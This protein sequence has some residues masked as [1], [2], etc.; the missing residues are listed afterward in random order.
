MKGTVEIAA[1]LARV[2]TALAA[3]ALAGCLEW[4]PTEVESTAAPEPPDLQSLT[5]SGMPP[6]GAFDPGDAAGRCGIVCRRYTECY[7]PSANP[8][9]CLSRCS[10]EQWVEDAEDLA[11]YIWSPCS[12]LSLCRE[13]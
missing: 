8:S 1:A 11:C 13:E 4:D 5:P 3:F 10:G 12:S 6:V 2:A 9:I 7:G